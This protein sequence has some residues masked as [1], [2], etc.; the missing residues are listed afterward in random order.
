MAINSFLINP[1]PYYASG[2]Q[3]D[4]IYPP[5]G[6]LYLA[7]VLEKNGFS[8]S[9]LDANVLKLSNYEVLKRI[10]KI[11]PE[12]VGISANVVLARA[13][14]ELAVMVKKRFP[15]AFIVM[16]GPIVSAL[17]ED[18]LAVCDTVVLHEG[19]ET[20]LEL[21]KRYNCQGEKGV[22]SLFDPI[23]GIAFK[24]KGKIFFT[25][26]RN[27]INNLD[28]IPFPA[29]H[30]L[31]PNIDFYSFKSRAR[32]IPV[33]PILTSRGCP[34]NCIYCNKSIFG[35]IFRVRTPENV[36]AEVE[37][38]IT[39]YGIRQIDILDDNFT[40]DQARAEKILDLII[41]AKFDLAL[42]CQN[43][44]RADKLTSKLIKKNEAGRDI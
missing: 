35:H 25:K 41:K 29:Y 37:Y 39:K 9:V 33:A 7:A 6:L 24:S 21:V 42:N 22:F 14:K 40:L 36:F 11:K 8:A 30:L 1:Y 34:F 17:P 20:F 18:F 19:E 43:G 23:P 38:L 32:K 2:I 28:D 16:G 10:K 13:A 31:E 44:I 15:K 26:P 3:E 27:F 5:L 12:I 4:T